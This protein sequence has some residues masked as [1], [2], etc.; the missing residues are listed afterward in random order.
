[1]SLFVTLCVIAIIFYLLNL[2]ISVY[3]TPATRKQIAILIL[4]TI[5]LVFVLQAAFGI[6][7]PPWRVHL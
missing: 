6:F 4:I 1:M 2:A 3:S 7:G 5:T